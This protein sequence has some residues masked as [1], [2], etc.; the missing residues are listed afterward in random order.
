MSYLQVLKFA[1]LHIK[2]FSFVEDKK[3]LK[4]NMQ[5]FF[6]IFPKT[7]APIVSFMIYF[8]KTKWMK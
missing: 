5:Q 4:K 2:I 1:V 7:R 6:I 8:L 3:L